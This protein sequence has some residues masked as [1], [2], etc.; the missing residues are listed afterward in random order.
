MGP[1]PGG[2]TNDG[3]EMTMGTHR[4]IQWIRREAGQT[5]GEYAVTLGVITLAVVTAVGLLSLAISG[6]FGQVAAK[7][8]SLG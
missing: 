4:W 8:T 6:Y 1:P 3:G 2:P 7:V 5:M